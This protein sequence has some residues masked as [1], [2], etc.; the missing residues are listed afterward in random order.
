[1]GQGNKVAIPLSGKIFQS[2]GDESG[3]PL[4]VFQPERFDIV[5]K[6]SRSWS[7]ETSQIPRGLGM[8]EVP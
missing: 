5:Q 3:L 6:H 8:R 1:M 4:G 2:F 7:S